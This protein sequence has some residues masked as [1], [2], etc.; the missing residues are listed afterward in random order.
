MCGVILTRRCLNFG[1]GLA[2]TI[3][4]VV[5]GYLGG[6]EKQGLLPPS[7]TQLAIAADCFREW[8]KKT[9]PVV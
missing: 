9:A 7:F 8:P 1:V 6:K 4:R 3:S 2:S 5:S